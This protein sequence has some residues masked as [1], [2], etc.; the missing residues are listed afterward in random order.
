MIY[1]DKNG[2]IMMPEEVEELSLWEIEDLGI[3]VSEYQIQEVRKMK[4]ITFGILGMMLLLAVGVHAHESGWYGVRSM[5]DE[6]EKVPESGTYEA[7]E[8][9]RKEG[10][11]EFI[12]LM[13]RLES[14]P[15]MRY[16]GC[17]GQ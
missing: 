7:L 16:G 13:N 17:Y 9:L 6:V 5:H 4:K 15:S 3:H 8:E 10:E 2:R 11:E 14:A 1:E 12:E